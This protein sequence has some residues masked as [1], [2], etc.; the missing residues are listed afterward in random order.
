MFF[1]L[2]YLESNGCVVLLYCHIKLVAV[3]PSIS[4]IAE[5]FARTL[6]KS[7]TIEIFFSCRTAP[8]DHSSSGGA[9]SL[10]SR[11]PPGDMSRFLKI[12]TSDLDAE[13]GYAGPPD[14]SQLGRRARQLRK[15]VWHDRSPVARVAIVVVA[16]VMLYNTLS[17]SRPAA[18][19]ERPHG[20]PRLRSSLSGEPRKVPGPES[21][22]YSTRLVLRLAVQELTRSHRLAADLCRAGEIVSRGPP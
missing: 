21:V 14:D 22:S 6:R 15:Q 16:I 13:K 7:S 1:F 5:S 19:E 20:S 9:L 10:A 12:S 17:G 8:R 18:R 11:H 2:R 4:C 3:F